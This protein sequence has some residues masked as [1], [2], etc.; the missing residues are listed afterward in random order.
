MMILN[1]TSSFVTHLVYNILLFGMFIPFLASVYMTAYYK[2]Q[3]DELRD[4]QSR[5]SKYMEL[6]DYNQ[7]VHCERSLS[8]DF[9]LPSK[10]S[11]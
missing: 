4:L 8:R 1:K 9:N 2:E 7:A 3:T 6:Q 5:F 10:N 11:Y